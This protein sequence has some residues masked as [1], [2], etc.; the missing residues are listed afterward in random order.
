MLARTKLNPPNVAPSA[1]DV[2]D[3]ASREQIESHRA[4]LD[5]DR[6]AKELQAA[7]SQADAKRRRTD[8]RAVAALAYSRYAAKIHK[9][10]P[11]KMFDRFVATFMG[12][13]QPPDDVHRRGQELLQMLQQNLEEVE[14]PEKKQTPEDLAQWFQ[15]QK[16]LIESLPI[17]DTFKRQQLAELNTRYSELSSKLMERLQP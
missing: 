10:F 8:A 9:R 14:P 13:D 16:I 17:D 2:R 3:D 1:R 7:A 15:N 4:Q 5:A 6:R 11:Q 12:D